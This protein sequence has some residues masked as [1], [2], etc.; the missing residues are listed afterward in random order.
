MS[1]KKATSCYRHVCIGR[2]LQMVGVVFSSRFY[3]D[4]KNFNI[5]VYC[6]FKF[7]KNMANTSV[8]IFYVQKIF[9]IKL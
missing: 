5:V 6:Y 8:F 9:L 1:T 3:L 2:Q 4:K 7:S